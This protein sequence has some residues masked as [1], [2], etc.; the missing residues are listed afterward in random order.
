MK[1]GVPCAEEGAV[2]ILQG[3]G[4]TVKRFPKGIQ[5]K[6]EIEKFSTGQKPLN[7]LHL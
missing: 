4:W 2:L 5:G 7:H 3:A 6:M 1:V